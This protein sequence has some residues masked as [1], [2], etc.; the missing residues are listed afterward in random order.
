M[1]ANLALLLI[2]LAINYSSS[3]E[4]QKPVESEASKALK[5]CFVEDLPKIFIDLMNVCKEHNPITN[6]VQ[7]GKD[8]Y[9]AYNDCKELFPKQQKAFLLQSRGSVIDI[10]INKKNCK[11][12]VHEVVVVLEMYGSKIVNMKFTADDAKNL[13]DF[14][15][16]TI[17]Y[18]K[19]KCLDET[20]L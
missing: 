7:L 8:I 9:T 16:D 1:K 5:Q 20:A 18:F 15:K 12:I 11:A 3:F 4:I 19:E 2:V 6:F 17:R 13:L 14:L 10:L